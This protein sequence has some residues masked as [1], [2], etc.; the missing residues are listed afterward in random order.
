MTSI[1]VAVQT[2]AVER[3]ALSA[4]EQAKQLAIL[5]DNDL[6]TAD[7]FYVGLKDIEKEITD[8][9]RE[10]KERAFQAHRAITAA[11]KRH[12]DPITEAR[13]IIKGKI[14]DY[15]EAQEQI[16][17]D[18]ERRL[19]E[20]ARKKAEDRAL[21]EAADLEKQGKKDEA[22]EILN[23]PIETPTVIIQN[24]TPKTAAKFRT[25]WKIEVY[26]PAALFEFTIRQIGLRKFFVPDETAV[27]KYVEATQGAME[28]PGVKRWKE[29]V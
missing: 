20:E 27:R 5:S 28:L 23:Q 3:K 7:Q 22:Q 18:E 13:R 12:L 8:T 6:V 2:E 19:Q 10:P 14:G 21:S 26:D 15:R 24:D 25:V 29:R 1:E 16:R 11:E 4:V 9:F 17:R